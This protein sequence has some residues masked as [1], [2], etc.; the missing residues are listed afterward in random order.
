M[1]NLESRGPSAATVAYAQTNCEDVQKAP[2]SSSL[3]TPKFLQ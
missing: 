2:K 1:T 3:R